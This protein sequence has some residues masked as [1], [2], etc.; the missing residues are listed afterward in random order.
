MWTVN[1]LDNL[2][3]CHETLNTC[4]GVIKCVPL[5]D[6]EREETIKELEPQGVTDI[7]YISVKDNSGGSRNTN[8]FI[9][10]FR[11]P[12][13]LQHLTVG[14]LIL[15]ELHGTGMRNVKKFLNYF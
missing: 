13:V 8:I 15:D 2:A 9:I 11:T 12:T 7:F 5:I 3:G 10:T 6:C 4:K 14:Y 1:K